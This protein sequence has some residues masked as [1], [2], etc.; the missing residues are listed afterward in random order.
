VGAAGGVLGLLLGT[1]SGRKVGGAA[2][3][4][5]SMAALGVV[6]V[7]AYRNWQTEQAPI[8][9]SGQSD[10]DTTS[11]VTNIPLLAAPEVEANSQAILKAMLAVAKSDGHLDEREQALIQAELAR[12]GAEPALQSWMQAELS[13]PLDPAEVARAATSPELAAQMYLASLLIAD[14]TSFMERAY[15]DELAKQLKLAP[16]LKAQLES[17]SV[18]I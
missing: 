12:T 13:R 16:E 18:A 15:L 8:Q 10:Q 3:K 9:S 4:Y 6:A 1:K 17:Q 14:E 2:L 7:K 5:G 11:P